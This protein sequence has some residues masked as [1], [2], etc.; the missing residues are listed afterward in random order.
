MDNIAVITG[1][2]CERSLSNCACNLV[3]TYGGCRIVILISGKPIN[4]SG[5]WYMREI[6]GL[7]YMLID[8]Y[9][10]RQIA[11]YRAV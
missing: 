7:L 4:D 6:I 11:R 3:Y 10:T 5:R 8:N 2:Y 9:H 1:I